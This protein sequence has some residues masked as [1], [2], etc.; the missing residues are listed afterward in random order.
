MKIGSKLL[1][2]AIAFK[3]FV[4]GKLGFGDKPSDVAPTVAL[5]E[6]VGSVAE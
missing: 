5:T 4:A 3:D 1:G 2:W 6:V